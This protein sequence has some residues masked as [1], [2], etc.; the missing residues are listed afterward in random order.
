MATPTVNESPRRDLARESRSRQAAS[1]ASSGANG[2]RLEGGRK[3]RLIAIVAQL[4]GAHS[5]GIASRSEAGPRPAKAIA[6][7]TGF[8]AR[9]IFGGNRCTRSLPASCRTV[10][11]RNDD[12]PWRLVVRC[13]PEKLQDGAR[14][15][16]V[17]ARPAAPHSIRS[18]MSRSWN[19]TMSGVITY[20]NRS[21][22]RLVPDHQ[23]QRHQR[24]Q[25]GVEMDGPV[26]EAERG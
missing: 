15:P 25:P 13:H 4:P 21:A 23:K 19:R 16:V 26:G 7:I 22:S 3:S 12:D 18:A 8:E 6:W 14:Q 17:Q 20:R 24:A 5:P 11:A 2:R 1:G 9:S 10:A